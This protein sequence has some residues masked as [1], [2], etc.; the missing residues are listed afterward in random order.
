MARQ[1][2]RSDGLT[3][4]FCFFKFHFALIQQVG[5]TSHELFFTRAT[6]RVSRGFTKY[7]HLFMASLIG[8]IAILKNSFIATIGDALVIDA[9]DSHS[10]VNVINVAFF[11]LFA[12]IIHIALYTRVIQ[13]IMRIIARLNA[14][15]SR[16]AL[17]RC[18]VGKVGC[19][20]FLAA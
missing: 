6:I 19:F 9:I 13:Q 14:A 16:S 12:T 11:P 4:E 5:V 2:S 8:T 10:T 1:R 20:A 17:D 18:R 3:L 15:R 7:G